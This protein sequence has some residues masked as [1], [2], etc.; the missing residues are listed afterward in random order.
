MRYHGRLT[1]KICHLNTDEKLFPGSSVV[2]RSA[3]N[4]MINIWQEMKQENI[5]IA[6]CT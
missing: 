3:V 1:K 6:A 4:S 5:A 2:E